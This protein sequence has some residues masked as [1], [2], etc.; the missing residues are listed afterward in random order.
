VWDERES[1]RNPAGYIGCQFRYLFSLVFGSQEIET[2][3]V[4][5]IVFGLGKN[6]HRKAVVV[7]AVSLDNYSPCTGV[8]QRK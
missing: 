3:S 6:Q 1:C 5:I 7:A 2:A 4:Q 8:V